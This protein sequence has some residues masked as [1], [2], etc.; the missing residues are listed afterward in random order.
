MRAAE[1]PEASLAAAHQRLD[2]RTVLILSG[3]FITALIPIF[4]TPILPLI[5]FYNHLARYFVL[6]HIGESDFLKL[7]YAENW[8]ILPNIGMDV[9]GTGLL[10]IFPPL[11]AAKLLAITILFTIY[12]GVIFLNHRLT[13]GWSWIVAILTVPLLYSYIFTWGFANFLLGLGLTF[14]AAGWWLTWRHRLTIATPIACALAI[15]IFLTHGLAFALYGL[16]LGSLEI[17]FFL[18]GG[19]RRIGKAAKQFAA[20]ALQAVAPAALFVL[21]TTAKSEEGITNADESVRRLL[22]QNGLID[23]L[24]DLTLYRLQTIVRVAEGP[25]LWFDLFTFTATMAILAAL[26]LRKRINWERT[27]WPTIALGI[28]LVGITPPALFGVGYVADRMPLF[29][30]LFIVAALTPR[31][32]GDRFERACLGALVALTVVRVG[33]ITSDWQQYRQDFSEFRSISKHIPP[34][35]IAAGFSVSLTKHVSSEPRCE[36]YG[37]LL[38]AVGAQAGPLF[39]NA[40][41]QPLKLVGDLRAAV[42]ALP[43]ANGLTDADAP[44]YFSRYIAAAD[45]AGQYRYLLI[46]QMERLKDPLPADATVVA[47]TNRFTLVRLAPPRVVEH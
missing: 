34:H 7:Y 17:G 38:I 11:V 1:L 24:V 35:N 20:L 30:A 14:W 8:S 42:D 15:I 13:G 27:T 47:R 46:C 44:N 41:Q 10:K 45:G 12:S 39:A 4:A 26:A 18:F 19:D 32:R 43:R 2:I 31:L 33:Y 16:L 25:T 23:R 22:A 40:T 3:I 36:M 9:I 5:D 29:L 21:T 28:L 37:P 6:A